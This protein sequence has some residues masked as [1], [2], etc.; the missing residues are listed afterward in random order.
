[1]TIDQ[2]AG[3]YA[4]VLWKILK[5]NKIIKCLTEFTSTIL[6]AA[7]PL[8]LNQVSYSPLVKCVLCCSLT[9]H[10]FLFFINQSS[11]LVFVA[12]IKLHPSTF[13]LTFFKFISKDIQLRYPGEGD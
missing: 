7:H 8:W 4:L 10:A 2:R 3:Q 13:P 12:L 11:R 5:L 9:S 6:S 1:M